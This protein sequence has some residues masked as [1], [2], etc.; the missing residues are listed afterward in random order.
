[1][2]LRPRW[3]LAITLFLSLLAVTSQALSAQ[4]TKPPVLDF[5]QGDLPDKTHDWTLGATG[6]RGWMWAWRHRTTDA[7]QILVTQVDAGSPADGILRKGDV[8]LGIGDRMF[9]SDARVQFGHALTEAEKTANGG[10]L[11][12]IRWRS[13]QTRHVTLTLKTLGSYCDTTP[14]G[15]EK[16]RAIFEQGVRAI[17]NHGLN[18]VSIPNDLNALALLASG[19]KAYHP[20]LADY[21]KQ[22]AEIQQ[23]GLCSWHYGYANLFLAEYYLATHDTAILPGLRRV[24]L[25]IA[26]GQSHVG[27][28]GHRFAQPNGICRGYGCM[29]QP[30]LVLTMSMVLARKAG[31]TDPDLDR[32]IK[33]ASS[34][35]R[36]YVGK[37][38]IP[39]G[40]HAPWMEHDD[41]GKNAMG[42]VLFDLLH[43]RAASSYFSRMTTAAYVERESGHTG[44]FFNL[45]W[46][47][48]G[49]SRSGPLAA[50]AH[51]KELAWYFDLA[52]R[53]DGRFIYQGVPA[54]TGGHSYG[55]WDSTGA[56]LLTYAL[57]RRGL[58]ILGKE[59]CVVSPMAGDEVAK[60][61]EAGRHFT[62][63]DGE[64][65]YD[66]MSDDAL[67]KRLTS[68][69]PI[70]RYRAAASLSH[71]GAN[72]TSRL[73]ALLESPDRDSQLGACEAIARLGTHAGKELVPKLRQMLTADDPWLLTLA[74]RALA[75][76]D[77][78]THDEIANE[79]LELA[80][81]DIP[82]DP[83][84]MVQRAVTSALFVKDR[85][86]AG[87]LLVNSLEQAD[88]DRL[89][90]AVKSILQNQDGRT[91][92]RLASLY[93]HVQDDPYLG[94]YLPL[95]IRATREPAPSGVMF[96]DG[97]RLAG[98][99]LL[100]RLHV[101]EGMPLCVALIGPDRWGKARRAPRCLD[102]LARYGGNAKV[103]LPE[104]L[105]TRAELVQAAKDGVKNPLVVKIDVLVQAI[106]QDNDPPPLRDARDFA[107][108]VR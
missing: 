15:C 6:A 86:Y 95:I 20:L 41:N 39:Y 21:A 57:P 49:V 79:L 78:T 31:V 60:T 8:I 91:R 106:Q 70:V 66:Q 73:A 88:R 71:H 98:L 40:D 99:D 55:G 9:D 76:V 34:F 93:K 26:R 84:R 32:A 65:S 25:E 96:S 48:P 47:M 94:L 82:N 12:L 100:S 101:R 17:A 67:F 33:T 59:P 30:G 43:D 72:C 53:W 22:V 46:A 58:Y 63:W 97:I 29:N 107:F 108:T 103:V 28:W 11:R 13:G 69:S 56:Y 92:G 83:R 45:L 102:C 62:F 3:R 27:T 75:S 87:G 14:Y 54:N 1:M 81:R 23:N 44:N 2:I 37:G 104:L 74:V 19:D 38:S 16:S 89:L 4:R 61:I 35:L 42:A 10:K 68:W 85:T 77:G 52:R 18:R 51:F 7:R 24:S 50:G 90:S 105:K 80:L 64:T 36:W 5:T